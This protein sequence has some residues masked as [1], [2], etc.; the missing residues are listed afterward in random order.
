[1][2]SPEGIQ[3]PYFA[4][5][6]AFPA[7]QGQILYLSDVKAIPQQT[8][9]FIRS[10]NE[11]IQL[12]ILDC[13]RDSI[14]HKSHFVL[15]DVYHFV[16]LYNPPHTVLVGMDHEVEHYSFQAKIDREW[17]QLN[18]GRRILVGHD[19]MIIKFATT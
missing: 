7:E 4:N 18:E 9:L 8:D 15:E 12:V 10:I 3:R 2:K 5:G 13:L 11:T 14:E 1:M 6:F 19:G 16:S 17:N